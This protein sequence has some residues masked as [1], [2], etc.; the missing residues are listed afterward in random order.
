[1]NRGVITSG[2][3]DDV[4]YG[5]NQLGKGDASRVYTQS[6]SSDGRMGAKSD[7]YDCL[8]AAAVVVIGNIDDDDVLMLS[9]QI[10]AVLQSATFCSSNLSGATELT[11][12]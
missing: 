8:V 7:V 1:M 3:V 2:S 12:F 9:C 5:H 6:D 10:I 4:M 11:S